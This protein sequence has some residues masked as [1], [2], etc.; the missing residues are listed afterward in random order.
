MYCAAMLQLSQNCQTEWTIG[1]CALDRIT[2]GLLMGASGGGLDIHRVDVSILIINEAVYF[3]R[4][5]SNS[6]VTNFSEP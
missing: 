4:R 2:S 5:C 1:P 6:H 3:P